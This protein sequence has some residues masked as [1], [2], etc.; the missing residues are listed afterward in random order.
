ML[1]CN[2]QNEQFLSS[3]LLH[4]LA[5]FDLCLGAHIVQ[6]FAKLRKFQ[7]RAIVSGCGVHVHVFLRLLAY[8]YATPQISQRKSLVPLCL[9]M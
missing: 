6:L 2:S 8:R 9:A 1:Y 3:L 7:L 4:N 5:T